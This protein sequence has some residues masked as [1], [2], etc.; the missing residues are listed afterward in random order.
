MATHGARTP[1]S[2]TRPSGSPDGS[3]ARD[4]GIVVR[5]K[6]LLKRDLLVQVRFLGRG[7]DLVLFVRMTAEDITKLA[8]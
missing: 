7:D 3:R 1:C 5:P 6:G 8:D 2:C 4:V